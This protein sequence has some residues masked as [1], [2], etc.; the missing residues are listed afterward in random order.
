M[1]KKQDKRRECREC[2]ENKLETYAI[3]PRCGFCPINEKD[4]EKY[5]ENLKKWR[6]INPVIFRNGT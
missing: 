5:S 2:G 6:S 4:L 1:D 3:C